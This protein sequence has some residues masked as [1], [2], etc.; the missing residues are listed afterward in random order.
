LWNTKELHRAIQKEERCG[1]L[2]F[3]STMTMCVCIQLLTLK[4]CWSISTG[5]C[6]TTL[7]TASISLQVTTT[8]LPTWMGPQYFNNEELF[9]NMTSVSFPAV[10]T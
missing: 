7:L 5:S 8:Y 3:G 6:L 1:M 9:P 4:H 10:T 2:T